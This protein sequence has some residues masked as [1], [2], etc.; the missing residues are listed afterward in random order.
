M[1]FMLSFKYFFCI[2]NII[3]L[4]SFIL[5][6]IKPVFTDFSTTS[7]HHNFIYKTDVDAIGF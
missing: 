4:R 6:S 3:S 1:L 7:Q 2:K 5:D